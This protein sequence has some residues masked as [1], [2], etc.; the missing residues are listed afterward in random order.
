MLPSYTIGE[1]KA[2]ILEAD[3]RP[4]D[5]LDKVVLWKV[6]MSEQEMVVIEERGG[7]KGGQMPWPYPPTAEVPTAISNDALTVSHYFPA[8]HSN[9]SMVSISVWIHPS[10]AVALSRTINPDSLDA[11]AFRYPMIFPPEPRRASASH[12]LPAR[13]PTPDPEIVMLAATLPVKG[14][15]GRMRR[16]RPT[17]AP[18]VVD[19]ADGASPHPHTFGGLRSLR[20]G[21]GPSPLAHT[22]SD[23]RVTGIKGLGSTLR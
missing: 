20:A 14:S 23:S 6:E 10:A 13:S 11:P 5:K 17:T 2:A 1:L 22:R 12:S 7:L 8:A 18:S 15:N 16:A 21:P 4:V 9:V 3:G 19:S